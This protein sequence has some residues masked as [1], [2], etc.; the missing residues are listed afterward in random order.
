VQ[1]P[2]ATKASTKKITVSRSTKRSKKSQEAEVFLDAHEPTS[3]SDDVS[4][5]TIKIFPSPC[6]YLY[7]LVLPGADEEI[8]RL[9]Y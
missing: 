6:V 8:H 5:C 9:G 3:S 7:V 2:R 4:D 1:A